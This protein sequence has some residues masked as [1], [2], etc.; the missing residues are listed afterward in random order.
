LAHER[1]LDID[2]ELALAEL[3]NKYSSVAI[4]LIM[5]FGVGVSV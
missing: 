5:G 2:V 4:G 3:N 1:L